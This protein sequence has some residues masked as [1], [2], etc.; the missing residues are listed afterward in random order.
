MINPAFSQTN[1][2][3]AV[4]LQQGNLGRNYVERPAK[5]V[6]RIHKNIVLL[7]ITFKIKFE[8]T[9]AVMTMKWLYEES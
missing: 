1:R 2:F 7:L 3:V 8:Q 9:Q 5:G 4:V 6:T